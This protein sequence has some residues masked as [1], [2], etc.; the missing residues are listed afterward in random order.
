[1]GVHP[2]TKSAP[3][4]LP[5]AGSPSLYRQPE[6][7][8]R[9]WVLQFSFETA[10]PHENAADSMKGNRQWLGPVLPVG[11]RSQPLD[12]RGRLPNQFDVGTSK[13]W[14]PSMDLRTHQSHLGAAYQRFD[15]GQDQY[16]LDIAV[17]ADL[18]VSQLQ[19]LDR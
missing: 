9:T 5:K 19:G 14:R 4:S 18:K 3:R 13:S 7:E 1:M 10:R 12:R 15:V 11:Q 6:L 16:L 2:L 17:G 8:C